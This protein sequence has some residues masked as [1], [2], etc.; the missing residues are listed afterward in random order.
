[1][2]FAFQHP[3]AASANPV[4]SIA[5]KRARYAVE[6]FADLEGPGAALDAWKDKTKSALAEKMSAE[7]LKNYDG[8]IFANTT[9]ILPLPDK[10]AFFDWVK[11]GHAFIAMHSG[12]DTFHGPNNTIDPYIAASWAMVDDIIEPAD[13]RRLARRLRLG[14][15]RRGEEA[16]TQYAK[17]R[18]AIHA[19][20]FR[21]A[22]SRISATSPSPAA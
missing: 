13:T 16:A 5:I 7:A 8:V 11:A 12:S 19:P 18:P 4:H 14:G 22:A 15:E 21:A 1:M 17:K 6:Y 9:G 3:I 20:P 10:Q 2:N